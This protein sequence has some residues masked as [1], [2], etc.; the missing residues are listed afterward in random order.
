MTAT[1]LCGPG[2]VRGLVFALQLRLDLCQG[3]CIIGFHR[4]RC[5]AIEF[6]VANSL[7]MQA[8]ADA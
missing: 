4:K 5:L 2:F 1:R 7:R 6:R 8:S 3:P